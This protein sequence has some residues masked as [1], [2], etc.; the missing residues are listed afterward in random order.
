MY[1]PSRLERDHVPPTPDEAREIVKTS[2]LAASHLAKLMGVSRQTL[3]VWCRRGS[4]PGR[5]KPMTWQQA[6]RM[7]DIAARAVLGCVPYVK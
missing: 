4:I 3:W 6:H 2:G 7:L 5:N 1:Q